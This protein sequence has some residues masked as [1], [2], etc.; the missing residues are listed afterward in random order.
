LDFHISCRFF[1]SWI[2]FGIFSIGGYGWA[3]F[4]LI[5][6]DAAFGDL[7]ISDRYEDFDKIRVGDIIRLTNQNHS[8]IVLDKNSDSIVVAEGNYNSSIHWGRTISGQEIESDDFYV[9][10]RYPSW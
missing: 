8:V 10:S 4:V 6:S 5:C 3:G 7:P 1:H 2:K 9:L